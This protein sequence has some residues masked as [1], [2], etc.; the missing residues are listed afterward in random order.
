MEDLIFVHEALLH[1]DVGLELCW[2]CST[3]FTGALCGRMLFA[4][5]GAFASAS[6]VS[7]AIRTPRFFQFGVSCQS[8]EAMLLNHLQVVNLLFE[9]AFTQGWVQFS[10]MQLIGREKF[11]ID[12]LHVFV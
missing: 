2:C 4:E 12:L 5:V 7:C 3:A 8:S 11:G 6:A 9:Y 1:I 10:Q